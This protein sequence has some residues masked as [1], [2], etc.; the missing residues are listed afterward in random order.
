VKLGFERIA[1]GKSVR[2]TQFYPKKGANVDTLEFE[3][4][5]GMKR[6]LGV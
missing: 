1:I 2:V 6:A 4:L 3:D 5:H